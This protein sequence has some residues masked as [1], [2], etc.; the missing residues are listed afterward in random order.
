MN[1]IFTYL[2]A[3]LIGIPAICAADGA[4][5][6]ENVEMKR[7]G[8]IVE[9]KGNVNFAY[10]DLHRQEVAVVIPILRSLDGTRKLEFAP[11][12]IAGRT[13][14]KVLAREKRLGNEMPVP[15][16]AQIVTLKNRH[17]PDLAFVEVSAFRSWMYE[18][19]LTA[20]IMVTGCADREIDNYRTAITKTPFVIIQEPVYDIAYAVPPVEEVK[21][22]SESHTAYINFVV[23]KY[24]LLRDY[25]Q[26]AAEL[27][28]VDKI[29]SE[30]RNDTN[31][32]INELKVTGYASPEG[33]EKS[34][35]LLSENRTKAFIN[36]LAD[37]FPIDR[38]LLKAEWKGDDWDG[39]KEVMEMSDFEHRNR[40]IY[41]IDNT[42]DTAQRKTKLRNLGPVYTELLANYYPQLRRTEYTIS[43][44]ARPFNIE[45]ARSLITTKPQ[46]LSLNEMYLVANSYGKDT[47][48]FKQAFDIAARLYPS[49]QYAKTNSAA[50]D[51]E[52][53]AYDAAIAR[54]GGLETPEALN[55]IGVA[56]AGKK[57]Y[58]K[59]LSYFGKAAELGSTIAR[60]NKNN[61][62][63]WIHDS[64]NQ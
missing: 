39:L 61:L 50:V 17:L 7:N 42:P 31:L 36:Y 62:E 63:T 22:R 12:A 49:D 10:F 25:K 6:F 48:E 13:R 28:A 43:Y 33:N 20:D 41:I 58:D 4:K 29:V 57:D 54:I 55:N 27:A 37:R 8:D 34:N 3:L 40:V 35:M 19:E 56:Y 24:E 9:I 59:A 18:A 64:N 53:G 11:I 38:S 52:N 2:T 51:I 45:E 14:S 26:N 1:K 32:T 47:P 15:A 21:Q 44:V 30:L 23:N 46:H 16:E 60:D 5:P